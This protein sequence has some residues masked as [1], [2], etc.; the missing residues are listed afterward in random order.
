[1]REWAVKSGRSA[2]EFVLLCLASWPRVSGAKHAIFIGLVAYTGG[3]GR[4]E[5]RRSAALCSPAWCAA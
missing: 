2:R 4:G 3:N 5:R 1:V